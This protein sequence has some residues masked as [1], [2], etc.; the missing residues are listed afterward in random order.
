MS[1]IPPLLAVVFDQGPR[2]RPQEHIQKCHWTI[3]CSDD[4]ISHGMQIVPDGKSYRGFVV[5]ED[6]PVIR[7]PLFERFGGR[8]S[9]DLT[10]I[11]LLYPIFF[12]CSQGAVVRGNA[13][14][15]DV[16]SATS[17]WSA[18]AAIRDWLRHARCH[19]AST[20]SRRPEFVAAAECERAKIIRARNHP[21]RSKS[22]CMPK[23]R[24]QRERGARRGDSCG[25]EH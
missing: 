10:R 5:D 13:S 18:F 24:R 23:R 9:I 3:A 12:P 21:V 14:Q 16:G 6:D 8:P 19:A 11:L 22:N 4:R 1:S 7:P 20:P 2:T 17:A 15:I 25:R